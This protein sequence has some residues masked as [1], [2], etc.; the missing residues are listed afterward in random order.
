MLRSETKHSCVLKSACG[1]AQE[2]IVVCR[3]CIGVHSSVHG[4]HNGVQGVCSLL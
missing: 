4:V 1:S 2:C 3:E